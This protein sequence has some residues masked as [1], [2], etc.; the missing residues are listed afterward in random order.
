M[1]E[2]STLQDGWYVRHVHWARLCHV[3]CVIRMVFVNYIYDMV[4]GTQFLKFHRRPFA[5]VLYVFIMKD[6][7][8]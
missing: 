2:N 6:I 4:V 8:R 3:P 5:R 1:V 7:G